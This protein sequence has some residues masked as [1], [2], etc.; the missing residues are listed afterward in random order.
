MD[1]DLAALLISYNY[2]VSSDKR[3]SENRKIEKILVKK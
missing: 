2:R 1:E 3:H